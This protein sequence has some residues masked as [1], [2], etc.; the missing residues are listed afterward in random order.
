M[1]TQQIA[2]LVIGA[3]VIVG[4]GW[5]LFSGDGET[6]DVETTTSGTAQEQAAQQEGGSSDDQFSGA[7]SFVSLMERGEQFQ[8]DFR[9]TDEAEVSGDGTFYFDQ[10][11]MRVDSTVMQDG[12]TYVSHMIFDTDRT[13]TWSETSEGTFAVVFEADPQEMSETDAPQGSAQMGMNEQVSMDQ[14]V[15]YDCRR[16]GVNASMFVPPSDIE[17]MDMQAMMQ[18]QFQGMPGAQ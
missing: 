9:Y 15:S 2:I 12:E 10:G 16:G 5:Y 1:S 6:H 8:C 14:R 7:G 17:F 4:G 18:G 3:V 13:Y 11:R